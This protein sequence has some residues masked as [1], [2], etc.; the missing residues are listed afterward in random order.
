[1]LELRHLHRIDVLVGC[2]LIALASPAVAQD[3]RPTEDDVVEPTGDGEIVVTARKREENLLEVPVTVAVISDQFIDEANIRDAYKLSALTPGFTFEGLGNRA[4]AKPVIRGV[5]TNAI[6]PNQQKNSSFI[7]GLFVGGSAT[8][9]PFIEIQRVEVLK[10]PQSATFGRATFSGAVSYVMKEPGESLSGEINAIA[11]TDNE[12]E[13]GVLIGGPIAGSTVRGQIAGYY[14]TFDG[15]DAWV[16]ADGTKLGSEK[17]YYGSA[18]LIIAPADGFQ[19]KLRYQYS[20]FED[21]PSPVQFLTDGQ[22]N[23]VFQVALPSARGA[24]PAGTRFTQRY[25]TGIVPDRSLRS[26]AQDFSVITD[27]G[28]TVKKHRITASVDADIWASHTLSVLAGYNTDDTTVWDGDA[29]NRVCSRP[30]APTSATCSQQL[31]S[32]EDMQIETRVTSANTEAIRYSLGFYYLSNKER[33]FFRQPATGSIFLGTTNQDTESYAPFGSISL[34]IGDRLTLGGEVRYNTD[35][36]TSFGYRSCINPATSAVAGAPCL[37][38]GVPIG[39]P[40]TGAPL[41]IL[42]TRS[43]TFK[44]WVYRAT[45]DFQVTDS[46][47][48]YGIYSKGTQPGFFNLGATVPEAFRVVDEEVLK[49]YEL[50]F[51]GRFSR[52]GYFTLALFNMDWGNQ[53]FR[54]TLNLA[55]LPGGVPELQEPGRIYPAGTTFSL[56]GLNVNQGASRIRGVEAEMGIEPVDGLDLRATVAYT[57]ARYRTFCSEFLF[58]LTLVPSRPGE[59][60][61]DVA[62]NRLEAQPDWTFSLSGG[63]QTQI[64]QSD[65]SGF[66]RS[67]FA[68]LSSKT[69]S[70]MNLANTDDTKLLSAQIGAERGQF[71]FEVFADNLLDDDTPIRISRLTD[72]SLPLTATGTTPAGGAVV[73][74]GVSQQNIALVPR[75]DRQFGIR[76]L[77]RF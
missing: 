59:V 56:L 33:T 66:I 18:T 10:G 65:W 2:S 36:V 11:A 68:Y 19:A 26:Y 9:P 6:S 35:K 60:C 42:E 67:D 28:T 29:L 5:T 3:V 40:F 8:P 58:Q 46:L 24:A 52:R 17:T 44:S 12:Y 49:N 48:V 39:N 21:G 62:G 1:M 4:N 57:R 23:G 45:A 63:Y 55:T 54:Q 30:G 71:R 43:Q 25:P 77:V 64:G 15:N 53:V 75:R 34:D 27:S 73:V 72:A 61:T 76:A 22:R 41:S 20:Q 16:N 47:L 70:E 74:S 37:F 14:R 38:A 7:D 31:Q 13:L 32:Y 51:K 50:G 69:E